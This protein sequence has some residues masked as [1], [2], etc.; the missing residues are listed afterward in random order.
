MKEKA[1]THSLQK[2]HNM[3]KNDCELCSHVCYLLET[4]TLQHKNNAGQLLASCNKWR[5]LRKDKRDDLVKK[6]WPQ[7]V[8]T[9]ERMGA[10]CKKDKQICEHLL[11]CGLDIDWSSALYSKDIM[12]LR[13]LACARRDHVA[14][15][16]KELEKDGSMDWAKYGQWKLTKAAATSTE[17]KSIVHTGT[18]VD[19]SDIGHTIGEDW[20]ILANW[21]TKRATLSKGRIHIG[22]FKLLG[23]NDK[24]IVKPE[25]FERVNQGGKRAGLAQPGAGD[26]KLGDS[27]A[28]DGDHDDEADEADEDDNDEASS[29]HENAADLAARAA[30]PTR[31][32]KPSAKRSSSG[33]LKEESCTKKP[34]RLA[35]PANGN[36]S[37]VSSAIGTT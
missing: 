20:H 21:D 23:K 35:P 5:L 8:P 11:L 37:A 33:A 15:G 4:G 1:H 26:G 27:D 14:A 34:R 3:L 12:E 10:A 6:L 31:S 7:L 30:A 9:D 22:I 29:E 2:V 13:R 16:F 28:S 18:T 36:G 24:N 25:M 19:L 17:C 32:P